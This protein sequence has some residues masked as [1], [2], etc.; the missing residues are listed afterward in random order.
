LNG[1]HEILHIRLVT[2]GTA[3]QTLIHP[4]EVFAE[5]IKDR[6]CAIIVCHN[7]PANS[8]VPSQEDIEITEQIYEASKVIGIKILDH[9][10]ITRKSHYS[11]REHGK[12]F[13][14][15]DVF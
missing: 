15:T 9:I 5:A 12:V 11:F 14:K 10:I 3:N 6:A 7:H 2:V 8:C 4:R 13:T 1:A